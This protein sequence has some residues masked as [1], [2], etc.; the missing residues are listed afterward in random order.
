MTPSMHMTATILSFTG[1]PDFERIKLA[2]WH[3]YSLGH[4]FGRDRAAD[5]AD[6]YSAAHVSNRIRALQVIEPQP[7]ATVEAILSPGEG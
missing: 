1:H 7:V 2:L 5:V 4:E 3:A 6:E